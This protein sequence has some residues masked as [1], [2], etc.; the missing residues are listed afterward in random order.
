MHNCQNIKEELLDLLFGEASDA[1]TARLEREIR[2]CA[3]CRVERSEMQ[4]TFSE[5]GKFRRLDVPAENYWQ[6]Y[7]ADLSRKLLSIEAP[8]PKKS[9]VA[10]FCRKFLAAQIHIP[11]PIAAGFAVLFA[12]AVF[13]AER[14]P[15]H[16]VQTSETVAAEPQIKIVPIETEKIV[17]REKEVWRDRVMTKTIRVPQFENRTKNPAAFAARQKR[18]SRMLE[19][20][21]PL[22]NLAEFQPPPKVEPK[23]VTEGRRDEK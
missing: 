2:L 21:V 5:Y 4:E 3:D 12:V 23:I 20:N 18:E 1:Q 9:F 17:F 22:L 11:V 15:V 13:F 10:N 19:A 16:S 6:N 7:E 14:V 8:E